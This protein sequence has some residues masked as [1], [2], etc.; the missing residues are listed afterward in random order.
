MFKSVQD[1]DKRWKA[2]IDIVK[3]FVAAFVSV[4]LKAF[5]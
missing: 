4:A 2:S 1:G 5:I 3:I